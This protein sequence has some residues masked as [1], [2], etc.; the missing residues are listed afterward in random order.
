VEARIGGGVCAKWLVSG[1]LESSN[2]RWAGL[3]L[4]EMGG[5][6]GGGWGERE[7]EKEE[8]PEDQKRKRAGLEWPSPLGS[9]LCLFF[10]LLRPFCP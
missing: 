7:S 8:R 9:R 3:L 2:R 4:F 1:D 5:E 6:V 10:L